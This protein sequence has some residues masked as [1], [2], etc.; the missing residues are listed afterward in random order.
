MFIK[1]Y[2]ERTAQ[3][4]A[5]R[6]F[7]FMKEHINGEQTAYVFEKTDGLL[8]VLNEQFTTSNYV[9]SDTLNY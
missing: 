9:E 1:L 5:E 4:L 2:D 3:G 7:A 8:L 6:G